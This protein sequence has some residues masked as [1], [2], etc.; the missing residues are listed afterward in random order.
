M[1][2]NDIKYIAVVAKVGDSV[3]QW[4]AEDEILDVIKGIL[5]AKNN[6]KIKFLGPIEGIEMW[7]RK[8]KASTI[9]PPQRD[10]GGE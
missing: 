5:I 9:N 6:G 2:T 1:N 4:C 7:S 8:D 3:Y 10:S